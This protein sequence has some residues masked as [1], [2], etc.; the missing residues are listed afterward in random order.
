MP[1]AAL[2][3]VQH[4]SRWRCDGYLGV[5]MPHAAL[6]VVQH[7]IEGVV[8]R[9]IMGFNAARS[10]VCGAT[11]CGSLLSHQLSSFNAARSIVCGATRRGDKHSSL[12]EV[13]MPHAALFV[14]Q[15]GRHSGCS[16]SS[17]V[18]MPHAALFVVQLHAVCV[19]KPDARSFNAARSI[20]CGAT[21]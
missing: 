1:H 16:Y 13:S 21:Q 4:D 19:I 8:L 3:V 5:S 14:V 6:F 10:I 7:G 15:R 20:V 18:S 11:S 17:A 9:P 12:K 2:F